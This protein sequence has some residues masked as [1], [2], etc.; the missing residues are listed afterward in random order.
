MDEA[1]Q[2]QTGAPPGAPPAAASGPSARDPAL[3]A[4]RA[5]AIVLVVM[6]HAASP[7]FS[8]PIGSGNWWGAMAWGTLARASVPLFFMC[9]GALM[10]GRDI[11]L[12]RL[13]GHNMV[14][15]VAA[16]YV[17]ALFYRV[18]HLAT[19]GGAGLSLT[20]LVDAVKHTLV[21]HHEFHFYFLHIM[22][23]V[24]ICLPVV[25]AFLRSASRREV[26]YALLVW[27]VTGILFPVLKDVWPFSLVSPISGWYLLPAALFLHRIHYVGVVF[28]AVWRYRPAVV[29]SV[30]RLRRCL[31]LCQL[32]APVPEVWRV[33]GKSPVRLVSWPYADVGGMV[34]TSFEGARLAQPPAP[35]DR[36]AVP[37]LVLH[38]FG[39]CVLSFPAPR[40]RDHCGRGTDLVDHSR[41]DG[42]AAGLEWAGLCRFVPNPSRENLF[43]IT[44]FV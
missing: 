8:F 2:N 21:L 34:W 25:R 35:G 13:Y 19:P 4:V 24:Y 10:L 3:D 23:L 26:E 14:R 9:S 44:Y 20:S 39:P 40:G 17:W 7:G 41:R 30:A 16:M 15:L 18:Y 36:L 32:L 29:S 28:A 6:T 12:R 31:H 43:D 37:G 38:L 33:G 22:L 42:A 27:F 1:Y 5:L 11:P